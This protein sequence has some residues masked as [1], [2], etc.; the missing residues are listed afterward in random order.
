MAFYA[1]YLKLYI[2]PIYW[3]VFG[4]VDPSIATANVADSPVQ[5]AAKR[6]SVELLSL[7]AKH[8]KNT[9]SRIKIKLLKIII[10]CEEELEEGSAEAFREQ[11]EVQLLFLPW[12]HV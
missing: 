9:L 7:F 5:L 12:M 4:S 3:F 10:Q 6:S 2:L 1:S 11:L 8:T